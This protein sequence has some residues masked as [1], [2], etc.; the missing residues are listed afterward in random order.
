MK[1]I[2][3]IIALKT[4]PALHVVLWAEK[5]IESY[6]FDSNTLKTTVHSGLYG[7]DNLLEV[8][9]LFESK[10]DSFTIEK[11]LQIHGIS[12]LKHN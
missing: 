12:V 8:I 3:Q 5:L 2:K 10:N 7:S 9:S 11:Q 1:N 6:R 4:F